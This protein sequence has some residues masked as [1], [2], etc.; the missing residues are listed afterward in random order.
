M[1]SFNL[2]ILDKEDCFP[3]AKSLD[4]IIKKCKTAVRKRLKILGKK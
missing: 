4:N 3:S 1:L 2:I